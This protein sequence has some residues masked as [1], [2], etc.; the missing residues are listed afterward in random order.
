MDSLKRQLDRGLARSIVSEDS[1]SFLRPEQ[2]FAGNI[3]TETAGATQSLRF[4]QI[5][6]ASSQRVFCPLA[7][8]HI[9]RGAVPAKDASIFV[10]QRIVAEQE[11]AISPVVSELPPLE[12]EGNSACE[13][14]LAFTGKKLQVFGMA[15]CPKRA[16]VPK[17]VHGKI[18]AVIVEQHFVR[19]K[20]PPIRG[21]DE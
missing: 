20:T 8:V 1:K 7:I 11:P 9:G 12:L 6:L 21:E 17:G 13:S 14:V 2:F 16:P 15:V 18:R 19:V 4:R 5:C 3:P 10:A